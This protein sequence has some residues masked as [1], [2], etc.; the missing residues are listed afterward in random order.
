M[1]TI[2]LIRDG[3]NVFCGKYTM[4]VT[5][6]KTF[7][8]DTNMTDDILESILNFKEINIGKKTTVKIIKIAIT[9]NNRG[10]TALRICLERNGQQ[11]RFMMHK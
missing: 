2:R 11:E 4:S 8:G 5:Q 3:N 10:G 7:I 6:F 1:E 9:G